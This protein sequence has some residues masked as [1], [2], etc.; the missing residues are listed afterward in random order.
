[1]KYQVVVFFIDQILFKEEIELAFVI[2]MFNSYPLTFNSNLMSGNQE[3][4]HLGGD[5]V[6]KALPS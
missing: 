4:T 2:L 1:M 6:M 5:W 3:V